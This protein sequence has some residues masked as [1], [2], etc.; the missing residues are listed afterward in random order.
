MCTDAFKIYQNMNLLPYFHA[1]I[2]IGMYETKVSRQTVVLSP[3]CQK[4]NIDHKKYPKF[5]YFSL[6]NECE[7][8]CPNWPKFELFGLLFKFELLNFSD[9]FYIS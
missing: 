9:F 1:F 7:K 6:R 8:I 2:G 4:I 3:N 5:K